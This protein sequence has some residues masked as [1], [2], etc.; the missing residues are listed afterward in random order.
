MDGVSRAVEGSLEWEE[1]DLNL[2]IRRPEDQGLR[3]IFGFNQ[4]DFSV[5]QPSHTWLPGIPNNGLLSWFRPRTQLYFPI[6]RQETGFFRKTYMV[7]P[8]TLARPPQPGTQVLVVDPVFGTSTG[9][10]PM[11]R[12]SVKV[13]NGTIRVFPFECG[14]ILPENAGKR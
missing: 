13:T 11:A 9:S 10:R 12:F 7:T 1:N 3:S 2:W 5:T 8:D 6:E 4:G 14:S